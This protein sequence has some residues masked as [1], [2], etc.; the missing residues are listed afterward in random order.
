MVT[1][2]YE[3]FSDGICFSFSVIPLMYIFTFVFNVPPWAFVV[4]GGVN[5]LLGV[6]STMSVALLTVFADQLDDDVSPNLNC[7]AIFTD[8]IG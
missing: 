5:Y 7:I 3:E 6:I 8:K 1:G 4:L 2:M